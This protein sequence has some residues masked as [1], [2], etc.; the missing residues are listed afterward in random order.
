MKRTCVLYWRTHAA[1]HPLLALRRIYQ[2]HITNEASV[3]NGEANPIQKRDVGSIRLNSHDRGIRNRKVAI[4]LCIMGNN[5][6]PCP[7]K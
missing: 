6:L 5:E 2:K 7:L 3:A 1:C 4:K